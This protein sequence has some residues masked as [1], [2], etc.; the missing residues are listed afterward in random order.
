M[1]FVALMSQG[2]GDESYGECAAPE[3]H[4]LWFQ[5]FET[6][7][8]GSN[9]WCVICDS[10]VESDDVEMW[11]EDNAGESFLDEDRSADG[12]TPCLFVYPT[13]D[14]DLSVSATCEA[15][16]CADE[17]NV[18]DPVYEGYGVWDL[19]EPVLYTD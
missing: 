16:A 5:K 13:G 11:V 2:C 12:V 7:P 10:S 3:A 1:A 15:A 8:L 19:I 6:G 17:A 4:M 14:E 9:A 18:N